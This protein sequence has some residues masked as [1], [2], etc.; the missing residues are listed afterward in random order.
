MDREDGRFELLVVD[1]TFGTEELAAYSKAI[2]GVEKEP[3]LFMNSKD[4]SKM[5]LQGK[6]RITLPLDRGRLEV[7]LRL[8]DHMAS[9]VIVVPRH[10]QLAWQKIEKWPVRIP[11]NRIGK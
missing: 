2:Q 9:G 4:A 7:Q 6:E 1:W 3:C 5:G 8:S 10:R 11:G